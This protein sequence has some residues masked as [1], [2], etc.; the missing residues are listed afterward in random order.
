M[1]G[2][3]G[4]G[5]CL[6]LWLAGCATLAI[7]GDWPQILGPQRNG[8]AAKGKIAAT[9]AEQLWSAPCGSGLAGVAVAD[10]AVVLFHRL[11]DSETLT[12][13]P[14][15]T[16]NTGPLWKAQAPSSYRA[17]IV[18]DN[19]PRAV[20]TISGGKV[21]TYGVQ[22][23]L[24]CVNLKTGE[25]VWQRDTHQDYDAPEGYFGAACSPLVVG[26][27]VIVNVGGR[28]DGG[29]VAFDTETGRTLWQTSTE[30][31]SYSSPVLI[32][33]QGKSIALVITRLNLLGLDPERGTELF[34]TPFGSRGPTVNGAL[35]VSIGEHVLLTASYG[36]GAQW[37]KVGPN[38]V[39]T[40][41]EDTLLSSQYT[42]P[43]VHQGHV[44]GVDG[45]QDG[46]PIALKCFNPSTRRV[47]WTESLPEY[48]T[49]IAADDKLLIMQS[50][51]TL[52]V[53][54][55]DP[56]AYRESGTFS[57]ARGTTRALPALAD[58]VLYIRNESRLMAFDLNE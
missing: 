9:K 35:P 36:I 14:A 4:L 10:G 43:I 25:I 48:A 54:A 40:V 34:R 7:A 53:A 51:G 31:A 19:G 39:E 24:S 11:D 57:L 50:N 52:R 12:A 3:Q 8:I 47:D 56:K 5:T 55:L 45:R 49:L 33:R 21:Y 22:G 30:L 23:R 58:G 44:Y 42:T 6:G 37:L 38:Q 18:D 46:G 2:R 13:F 28:K 15:R 20:P 27:R 17:Q 26:N 16:G 1:H 32:E 29:V 41:W